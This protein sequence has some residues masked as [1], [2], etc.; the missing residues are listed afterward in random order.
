MAAWRAGKSTIK[1]DDFRQ[2]PP[3]IGDGNMFDYQRVKFSVPLQ[4]HHV[5]IINGQSLLFTGICL[6]PN[7]NGV[8]IPFSANPNG[9]KTL[10]KLQKDLKGMERDILVT[11]SLQA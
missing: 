4:T 11:K 7:K 1:M 2:T 6:S 3:F 8:V 10:S 5:D 9:E